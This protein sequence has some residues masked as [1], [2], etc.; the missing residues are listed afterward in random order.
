MQNLIPAIA[1]RGFLVDLL[2]VRNHGPHLR[3]MAGVRIVD[4][5]SAHVYSSFCAVARY[6]R[7]ERPVAMLCDKDKVNRTAIF[8]KMICRSGTSLVLRSGTT[9]SVDLAHRSRFDR[10][11]QWLSMRVLYR[12]ATAVVTP[13]EA[14]RT[15][16]IR[17][18]GLSPGL[19]KSLRS[20]LIPSSV[21]TSTPPAPDHPWFR[22]GE[23]PVILS[24]GE[25]SSRKDFATLVEAFALLRRRHACRLVILGNGKQREALLQ[26]AAQRGVLDDFDL[27]GFKE[28]VFSFMAHSK[29]FAFTSRWEGFGNVLA[30]AMACGIPVVATNCGAGPSELLHNYQH[31]NLVPIGDAA[32]LASGI[33]HWLGQPIERELW[34]DIVRGYEIESATTGYLTT[35]GLPAVPSSRGDIEI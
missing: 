11:S 24:V 14:A 30:E 18:A 35:L 7:Q 3:P 29:V 21:F 4:L 33:E 13:S 28:N 25:L 15:D 9:I 16:L 6:L 12:Y 17:F 26:L 20:P 8:A 27:P 22:P 1:E 5:G 10:W 19:V 34:R 31:T 23:P 2:K 32:A